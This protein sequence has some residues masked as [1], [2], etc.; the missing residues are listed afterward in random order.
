MGNGKLKNQEN[1]TEFEK[2]ILKQEIDLVD[3]AVAR[4]DEIQM[5]LKNWCI[6]VWGGSLFLVAKDL[7][8]PPYLILLTAVVPVLFGISDIIWAKQMLIVNF[9]EEKISNFINEGQEDPR[10]TLL[11]PIAKRY[12]D[13]PVFQSRTSMVKAMVHKGIWMFYL[14]LMFISIMLG[15]FLLMK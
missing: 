12:Q 2:D 4:I 15:I 5:R 7:G 3:K 1:L 8:N 13:D 10:F 9:R 6:A 14:S 11:D